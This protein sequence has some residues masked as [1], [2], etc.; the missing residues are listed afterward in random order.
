MFVKHYSVCQQQAETYCSQMGQVPPYNEPS[1]FTPGCIDE[2]DCYGNFIGGCYGNMPGNEPLD[3]YCNQKCIAIY[4]HQSNNDCYQGCLARQANLDC[5]AETT[6]YKASN[7]P[8]TNCEVDFQVGCDDDMC[9]D[10]IINN[11]IHIDCTSQNR[12]GYY[13]LIYVFTKSRKFFVL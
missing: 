6:A 12:F 1:C 7:C 11:N 8:D 2:N 10:N 9:Y 4:S 5:I 13:I 3:G